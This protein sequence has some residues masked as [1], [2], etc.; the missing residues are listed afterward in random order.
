[1]ERRILRHTYPNVTW[2]AINPAGNV[3]AT[4]TPALN[5]VLL[6]DAETASQIHTI[7]NIHTATIWQVEFTRDGR[8]I[9][10]VSSDGTLKMTDLNTDTAVYTIN[11]TAA[12]YRFSIAPDNT[13]CITVSSP[14]NVIKVWNVQ[15]GTE[16]RKLE[17]HTKAIRACVISPN[18]RLVASVARDAY[19]LWNLNNG[20]CMRIF[21]ILCD[22]PCAT[23]AFSPDSRTIAMS[24][25]TLDTL[26]LRDTGTGSV[27]HR[28]E[29]H[30]ENVKQCMFT[31]SGLHLM[32]VTETN[33]IIK[34]WDA[35]SGV[36]VLTP[37]YSGLES[38]T[39][40]ICGGAI[41]DYTCVLASR[42]GHAVVFRLPVR[43][44]VRRLVLCAILCGRRN[45]R[46]RLP[47]E[48]WQLMFD[49]ELFGH[50]Y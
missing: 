4:C 13:A 5:A 25:D 37:Q 22:E 1:M 11:H 28:L 50:P 9:V 31:S 17:G 33:G 3:V 23:M 29:D 10:T 41:T 30:Y 19:R 8:Y 27:L 6:W 16:I 21:N 45:G 24:G 49:D 38:S 40:M 35:R 36:C 18:G 7:Q 12:V 14:T 44:A 48:L 32:A 26:V 43:C 42:N 39:P 20:E 34:L 15:T 46:V 2:C 47:E